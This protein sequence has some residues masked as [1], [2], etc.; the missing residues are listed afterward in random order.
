MIWLKE[1]VDEGAWIPKTVDITRV[2]LSP[3][4]GAMCVKFAEHFHDSWASRKVRF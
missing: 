3:E 1:G 2:D 4:M